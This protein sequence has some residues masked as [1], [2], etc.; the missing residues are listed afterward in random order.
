VSLAAITAK[1]GTENTLLLSHKGVNTDFYDGSGPNDTGWNTLDHARSPGEIFR[2][3]SSSERD[4]ST[5]I[6]SPHP[7]VCPSLWCDGHVSNIPYSTTI[8]PQLWAYDD[9]SKVTPP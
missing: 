7:T 9:G 1:K 6:S 4:L 2:D 3:C 8:M 5:L